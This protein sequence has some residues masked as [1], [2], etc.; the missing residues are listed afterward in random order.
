MRYPTLVLAL[1]ISN[2]YTI[3]IVSGLVVTFWLALFL[4][5]TTRRDG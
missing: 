2:P 3:Y 5:L 1:S 4:L